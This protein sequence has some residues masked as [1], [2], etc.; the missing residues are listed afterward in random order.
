MRQRLSNE[1]CKVDI[2]PYIN[3]SWRVQYYWN[4]Q[5]LVFFL[6]FDVN[7]DDGGYKVEKDVKKCE[8]TI[9]P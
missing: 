4:T 3:K 8:R 2:S 7:A 1:G 6:S 5:D 9:C